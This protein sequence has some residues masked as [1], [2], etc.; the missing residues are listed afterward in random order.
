MN[1]GLDTGSGGASSSEEG[2]GGGGGAALEFVAG[3]L[4]R[5]LASISAI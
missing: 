5:T 4:S 3:L 1:P 2:V